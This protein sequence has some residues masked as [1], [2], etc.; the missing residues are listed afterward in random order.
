MINYEAFSLACL[1]ISLLVV[2]LFIGLIWSEIVLY[3]M[4]GTLL[5]IL[6]WFLYRLFDELI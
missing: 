6:F 5:V 3:I 4:L 1:V 2:V